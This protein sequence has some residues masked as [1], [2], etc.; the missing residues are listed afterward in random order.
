MSDV[1]KERQ[2][3]CY[4]CKKTAHI[5]WTFCPHCGWIYRKEG[6]NKLT[7]KKGDTHIHCEEANMI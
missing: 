4:H 7:F 3:K 5:D 6:K 1:E 2:Q